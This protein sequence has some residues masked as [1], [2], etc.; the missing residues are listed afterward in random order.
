MPKKKVYDGER[1]FQ[2]YCNMGKAAS[3]KKITEFAAREMPNDETGA[4][5]VTAGTSSASE[6]TSCC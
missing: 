4:T 5:A 6:S 1:L 2:A 3:Y